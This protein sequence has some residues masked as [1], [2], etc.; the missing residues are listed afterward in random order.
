[1]IAL[2]LE[3]QRPA[4]S[5]HVHTAWPLAG[6]TA[7]A[8]PSGCGKT[9]LLRCIAGL[10]R[11]TGRVQVGDVLWQDEEK[12]QYKNNKLFGFRTHWLPPHRRRV[13]F[14]FQQPGLFPHLS[15]RD[16]LAYGLRRTPTAQRRI[17]L[18]AAV[19]LL[20]I[21]AL[22]SRM[23]HTLSG[24][25][26]QRAAIA[27]AVATSPRLLL[28]DEPLSALDAERRAEVLPW[29]QQLHRALALPMLYVS[30]AREEITAIAQRVVSMENGKITHEENLADYLWRSKQ[31][32]DQNTNWHAAMMI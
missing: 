18:D 2:G 6:I 1:M 15:V 3:L 17:A 4:F 7:I 30:H 12:N 11:A 13:G 20:G 25:E 28:L 8:G 21:A 14:I 27:R 29:L 24:G 10:E 5:L 22:L 16:N 23:P 19:T 26:L 31:H 9:T 32:A